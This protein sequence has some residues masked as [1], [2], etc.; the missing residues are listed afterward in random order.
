MNLPCDLPG[1]LFSRTAVPGEQFLLSIPI[2]VEFIE[3]ELLT[4][5]HQGGS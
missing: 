5:L 1:F 4:Y 2:L 3:N